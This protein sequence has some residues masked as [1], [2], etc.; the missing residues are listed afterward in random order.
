MSINASSTAP[1]TR[2][3]TVPAFFFTDLVLRPSLNSRYWEIEFTLFKHPLSL[4][5]KDQLAPSFNDETFVKSLYHLLNTHADHQF[6]SHFLSKVF[7]KWRLMSGLCHCEFDRLA[8]TPPRQTQTHPTWT[9]TL[10]RPW[11]IYSDSLSRNF[12]AREKDWRVYPPQFP[13]SH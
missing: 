13:L 6:W 3:R 10:S 2:P 11:H 9:N 8:K 1:V 12:P 7:R 5:R 4:Q